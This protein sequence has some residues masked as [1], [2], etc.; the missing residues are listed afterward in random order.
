MYKMLRYV[1]WIRNCIFKIELFLR[2]FVLFFS[3]SFVLLKKKEMLSLD[4]FEDNNI[5]DY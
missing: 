1:L 4:I 2:K 5:I 3:Y